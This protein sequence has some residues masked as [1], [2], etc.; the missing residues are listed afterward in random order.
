[1]TK[2]REE[3]WFDEAIGI[4]NQMDKQ[5]MEITNNVLLCLLQEAIK[6]KD[7]KQGKELHRLTKN[8]NLESDTFLGTF[9]IRFYSTCGLLAEAIEAFTKVTEMSVYTWSAMISAH[10]KLGKP[11]DGL[12]VYKQMLQQS[13]LVPE[14]NV[15]VA[16][17]EACS[18][19]PSLEDGKEVHKFIL[20]HKCEHK[21]VTNI[22]IGCALIEMYSECGSF[23]EA[24]KVFE[25]LPKRELVLWNSM[26]GCYARFNRV[27]DA[28]RLI[29]V[30]QQERLKPND[31]T[32]GN[33]LKACARSQDLEQGKLV[34]AR[35]TECQFDTN[36]AV[37]NALMDM[38][39]KCGN[40]DG[41]HSV[42]Y[43]LRHRDSSTWNQ[44]ANGYMQLG[45]NM[46]GGQLR[47][48]IQRE[49]TMLSDV[50]V[51]LLNACCKGGN[52]DEM[53]RL[54]ASAVGCMKLDSLVGTTLVDAYLK[55]TKLHEARRV[56]DKWTTKPLS[57]W[58]LM[59]G[60]YAQQSL[61]DDAL[62]LLK[63]M[64]QEADVKP[65]E[66]TFLCILDVCLGSTDLGVGKEIH[67]CITKSGLGQNAR[68]EKALEEMYER[69]ANIVKAQEA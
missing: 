45:D 53:K 10:V 2:L 20:E 68:L 61:C 8:H 13:D 67:S 38:Y 29:E 17:L 56:F 37:A 6:R 51:S 32:F 11:E 30:L 21:C 33:I 57:M 22:N 26:I 15:F 58:N 34:H 42:L 39:A 27:P 63:M 49:A 52:I 62:T 31:A 3:G 69:C 14:E 64:L 40:L 59:I 23:E 54:H 47:G 9:L 65:S 55:S 41:F 24:R 44:V 36:L 5:G 1:M 48:H 4:V 25:R 35:I 50:F 7:L 12:K 28:L 43:K 46:S 18:A 16:T 19:I 60:G 66:D